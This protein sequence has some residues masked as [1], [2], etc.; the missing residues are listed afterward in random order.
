[1]ARLILS[2]LLGLSLGW[3]G[4][5]PTVLD[6]DTLAMVEAFLKLPTQNLPPEHIP[7]FLAVKPSTL[8][9]KL[10]T[11]FAAKRLELYTL[12][13][14]ADGKRKGSVRMPEKD[15]AVPQDA[16]STSVT[17]LLMAGFVEISEEEEIY[18]KDETHCS[19]RAMMCEFSLQIILE[20]IGRKGT[21]HR[22]FF[23]HPNDPLFALVGEYRAVGRR[24]QTNFFGEGGHALC[25]SGSK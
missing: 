22:R 9:K 17:I 14:M 23:L 2:A 11:A 24:R 21:P 7:R 20:R 8:P 15:C 16:K 1:M 6:K 25:A 3:A 5:A 18:L 19:E 13:Q 12:K 4:E 10:R